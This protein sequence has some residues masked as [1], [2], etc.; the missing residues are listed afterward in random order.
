[1]GYSQAMNL[2]Q[3]R[4]PLLSRHRDVHMSPTALKL[5]QRHKRLYQLNR[6]YIKGQAIAPATRAANRTLRC[7]LSS[8]IS[9]CIYGSHH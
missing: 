5:D 7:N 3:A 1:M 2:Q 9:A 4:N 6:L 8:N